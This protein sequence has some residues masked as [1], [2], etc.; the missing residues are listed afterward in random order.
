VTIRYVLIRY[1]DSA[2]AARVGSGYIVRGS[3]VL[4]ANH[5][6]DGTGHQVECDGGVLGIDPAKTVLSGTNEV[7]L[8]VLQLTGKPLQLG[9]TSFARVGRDAM[10]ISDCMAVGFPR[11]TADEESRQYRTKQIEGFIRTA[12]RVSMN[13]DGGVDGQLLRLTISWQPGDQQVPVPDGQ[14]DAQPTSPWGGMSGAVVTAP[15]QSV[16]GVIH[17]HNYARD[18]DVLTVTPLLALARLPEPKQR[19]FYQALGILNLNVLPMVNGRHPASLLD[20]AVVDEPGRRPAPRARV[21]SGEVQDRWQERLASLSL[22]VPS[23]W[24]YASLERLYRDCEE[25]VRQQGTDPDLRRARDTAKALWLAAAAYPLASRFVGDDIGITKLQ[26]LYDRHVQRPP[27]CA[28]LDGM[29]IDAAGVGIRERYEAVNGPG[30][31]GDEAVTALARF[32]LGIASHWKAGQ[33]PGVAVDLDLTGLKTWIKEHLDVNGSDVEK[34]L[35]AIRRRFW[36]LIEFETLDLGTKIWGSADREM[37]TAII[38]ETVSD[39]GKVKKKRF[40]CQPASEADVGELLRDYFKWLP[41][42][43]FVVDL[44]MPRDWLDAHVEYWDLLDVAGSPESLSKA[45]A[46]HLRWV[47]HRRNGELASRLERRFAR[48]GWMGDPEN[49]PPDVTSD[50]ALLEAWLDDRNHRGVPDPP[51]FIGSSH[52]ARDCDP[53]GLLLREGY[54]FLVWFTAD[55]AFP[56]PEAAVCV[57]GVSPSAWRRKDNLYHTLAANVWQHKPI[58]IWS[59]PGRREDFDMPPTK[60]RGPRRSVRT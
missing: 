13:H 44:V 23:H 6:A 38:I 48:I 34:Y 49:I 18:R 42:G 60:S 1:R 20:D 22:Q 53:L 19:E 45:H 36:A 50:Q 16:I 30:Q 55:A 59:E 52:G 37:P 40:P 25:R 8:G 57:A 3:T 11:W 24:D 2:N 46:P 7:D 29:L 17:S 56:I 9:Q 32:M 58:I 4:T 14:L 33:K 39:A 51:Y 26:Y 31:P 10:I 35:T 41:D 21:F 54:G 12:D 5:V 15:G 47:K 27:D 28:T 43:D